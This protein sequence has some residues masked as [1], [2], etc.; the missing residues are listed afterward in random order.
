MSSTYYFAYIVYWLQNTEYTFIDCFPLQSS[1]RVMMNIH[2][3]KQLQGSS[4]SSS[5]ASYNVCSHLGWL[6]VNNLHVLYIAA[7]SDLNIFMLIHNLDFVGTF[8]VDQI[9]TKSRLWLFRE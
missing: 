2:I 4:T 5:C 6:D 8:C 9:E 7:L 3:K 1:K